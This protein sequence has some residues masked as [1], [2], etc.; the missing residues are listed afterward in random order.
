[1]AQV[2]SVDLGI[3]SKNWQKSVP[4]TLQIL[5]DSTTSSVTPV[6]RSA[7]RVNTVLESWPR[8]LNHP[9]LS[10][11]LAAA[12]GLAASCYSRGLVAGFC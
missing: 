1:M 4:A 8:C 3:L 7:I 5:Q 11:E 2:N 12:K 6:R 9:R 10:R